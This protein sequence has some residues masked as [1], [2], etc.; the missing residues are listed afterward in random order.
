MTLEDVIILLKSAESVDSIIERTE[1]I[2][3]LFPVLKRAVGYNQN[4]RAHQYDLYEHSLHTVI[5][6]P[7]G[8]DDDMLYLAALLHDVGKPDCRI[9]DYK[10]GKLNCHYYGHPVRSEEIVQ[11]E[12]IPF[13]EIS[14]EILS[15]ED[16]ER[17]LYYVRHHDDHMSLR[18]KHLREHLSHINMEQFKNLMLLEV[19]DAK[20]HVVFDKIQRRIA[21]CEQ[22][23]GDYAD[24]LL[25]ELINNDKKQGI[26]TNIKGFTPI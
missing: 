18:I 6:L 11:Q 14:G 2:L 8:I 16:K 21:V 22:L 5:N 17:L 4:N 24:F 12:V 15:N 25:L 10:D 9:I 23:S 19:A 3:E 1:E 13:L 7:R 26:H 20:A